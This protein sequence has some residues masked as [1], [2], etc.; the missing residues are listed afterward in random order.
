FQASLGDH[1]GSLPH[2]WPR[3]NLQPI[4]TSRRIESGRARNAIEGDTMTVV[5]ISR[6]GGM[7]QETYEQVSAEMGTEQDPPAGLIVHTAADV[8]GA[9]QDI[10]DPVPR[11]KPPGRRLDTALV[12]RHEQR[13]LT[14]RPRERRVHRR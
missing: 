9:W 4:C 6:G 5:H 10:D 7:T 2:P 13:P 14:D 12:L 11:R 1:A 8:D 3:R